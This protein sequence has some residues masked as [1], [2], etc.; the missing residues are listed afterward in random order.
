MRF[1]LHELDCAFARVSGLYPI[2]I[3]IIRSN[4]HGFPSDWSSNSIFFLYCSSCFRVFCFFFVGVVANSGQVSVTCQLPSGRSVMEWSHLSRDRQLRE[5]SAAERSVDRF[6]RLVPQQNNL[7]IHE[8]SLAYAYSV[9]C[10]HIYPSLD[11]RPPLHPPG[12]WFPYS[13]KTMSTG[14]PSVAHTNHVNMYNLLFW[15][16]RFSS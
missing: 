8:R 15:F 5:S 11:P 7:M 10:G 16:D 9:Q 1:T 3:S 4:W 12:S 14:P 13:T 2:T 6:N